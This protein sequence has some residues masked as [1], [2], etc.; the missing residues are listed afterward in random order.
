MPVFEHKGVRIA[1]DE[2]G[3]LVDPDEWTEEIARALAAREGVY[4]LTPD[5]LDIIRFMRE[6]YRKYNF[7]PLLGAVC[8]NI[9]RPRDCFNEVFMGP[10]TA[11]KIAGLP[12][13]DEHVI[14]YLR[15]EGGVT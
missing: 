4:E 2:E 14:A 15:G 3:Y 8:K 5:R 9:H 13:P 11:W 1:V 10:L 12:K 6:Y 7:F